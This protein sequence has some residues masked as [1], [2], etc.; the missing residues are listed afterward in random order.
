MGLPYVT[1]ND[2]S[3]SIDRCETSDEKIEGGGE[4]GLH[5]C[6]KIQVGMCRIIIRLKGGG[7][8]TTFGR[9]LYY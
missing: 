6:G 3:Q 7:H 2:G 5:R 4:E 9:Y 8:S 1:P